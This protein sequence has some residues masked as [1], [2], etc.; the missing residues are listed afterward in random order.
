MSRNS[1]NRGF[2]R[3]A[4]ASI[5]V[6]LANPPVNARRILDA[7]R[8]ADAQAAHL[9]TF[10][11]LTLTGVS[12]GD[13]LAEE[14]LLSS[15]E[16]S[17]DW[18][19]EQ[20]SDLQPLLVVGAPLRLRGQVHSAAVW[21]HRGHFL[22]VTA[23]VDAPTEAH[24]GQSAVP[25]GQ[26]R[27]IAE[28]FERVTLEAS[29][30]HLP[31]GRSPAVVALLGDEEATVSSS[32][33]AAQLLAAHSQIGDCAVAYAAPGFGESTNDFAWDGYTG[34][35][36][37]GTVLAEGERFSRTGALS[38]ADIDTLALR[39][40]R[41]PY[42][43]DCCPAWE[44]LEVTATIGASSELQELLRPV[45]KFPFHV[46]NPEEVIA[47]QVEG[48]ARRMEAI[49][50][51]KLLVGVSG[52]LDSTLALVVACRAM[53]TLG[54]PRTDILGYTMPGFGTSTTSRAN[55]ESLGETL[56]ISF[57][58]LDIRPAA[59]A[60]LTAL[61]HPYA[62]GE[63]K[64]D[65]TFENV[66]AGL[67]TDYLFRLANQH[68]GIVV[69]TGDL[70]ELALGWCTYGV[71]DQMS[72]YDVNAGVPKTSIQQALRHLAADPSQDAHL[73]GTLETILGEEI[74]PELIP[75]GQ[76]GD[77]QST[78][79][80]IGPY[81]LHDFTL[82]YLLRFGFGPARIAF[83]ADRAWGQKY[84]AEEIRH[85][86]RVFYRR[87]FSSQFKREAA[88]DGPQVFAGASLSPREGWKMPSDAD[89]SIW[90]E[91]LE[92]LGE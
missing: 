19:R 41:D 73:R 83:L 29:I 28:D 67:R 90:L 21:I 86:L 69:G 26:I 12:C 84:S 79:A 57:A 89:A 3:V 37:T 31:T 8:A 1:N 6:R 51:P 47:L 23:S 4:A 77:V 87:F 82:H 5:P 20:S 91:E 10:P 38:I 85:W 14:A 46:E 36:E 40:L 62:A 50:S 44:G 17:L 75:A 15:V 64:Y 48:L 68:G 13:L 42:S 63:P 76:T 52:G 72:H 59:E 16:N 45:D 70:S 34:I 7:V 22:G 58:E 92:R 80:S 43:G 39:A 78:E 65:V 27:V 11:A 71:G 30:G 81:E 25:A 32:K 18:L 66:Q 53:D 55:A 61:D 33:R 74:S 54:R 88:P 2:L 56:G 9:V 49:G 60:M 24:I 35:F